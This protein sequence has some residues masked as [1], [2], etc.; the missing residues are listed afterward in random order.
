MN[1]RNESPPNESNPGTSNQLYVEHARVALPLEQGYII[2]K[3][4]DIVY[5]E[6]N[7]GYTNF[8]LADGRKICVSKNIKEYDLRLNPFSFLRIHKSYL[9]NLNHVIELI[10]EGYIVVTGAKK[11]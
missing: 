9:I 11:I 7:G 5:C 3:S 10:N 1:D 4:I 2:I 6:G 8:H